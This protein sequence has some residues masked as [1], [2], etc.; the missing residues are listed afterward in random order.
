VKYNVFLTEE[1]YFQLLKTAVFFSAIGYSISRFNLS[2]G[3]TKRFLK[4][5]SFRE[6]I[7]SKIQSVNYQLVLSIS[8]DFLTD[9]FPCPTNSEDGKLLFSGTEIVFHSHKSLVQFPSIDLVKQLSLHVLPQLLSIKSFTTL[10]NL[11]LICCSSFEDVS[12][13]HSLKFLHLLCC[14]KIK[15]VSALGNV[16]CLEIFQC[17][18]ISDISKLSNNYSLSI[19]Y[20]KNLCSV[21]SISKARKFVTNMSPALTKKISFPNLK[22]FHYSCNRWKFGNNN[23]RLG[24]A[25]N[26]LRTLF[27]H[28]NR[29]L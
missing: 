22:Q 9:P 17:D 11:T 29:Q 23:V 24:L 21:P 10:S 1:E 16:H 14:H 6:L 4:D 2:E 3:L 18:N 7:S 13:F 8:G 25:D 5:N 15:D 12:C 27:F 20:L 26:Q 19:Q 28:R